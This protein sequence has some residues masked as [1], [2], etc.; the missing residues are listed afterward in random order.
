MPVMHAI[1]KNLILILFQIL[2][3][4]SFPNNVQKK[5]EYKKEKHEI[6]SPSCTDDFVV[7]LL[8]LR[9]IGLL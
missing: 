4:K 7:K 3:V 5:Y 6:P 9:R 2:M 1:S 8:K